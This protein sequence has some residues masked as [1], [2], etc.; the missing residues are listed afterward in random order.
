MPTPLGVPEPLART[1]GSYDFL[2]RRP[3]GGPVA[4][5]PC[6]PVRWVVRPD[7]APA[8]GQQTVRWAFDRLSRATGLQFVFEGTTDEAPSRDRTAYQPDRYG[9]RWA[10]LLVAWSWPPELRDLE[11]PAAGMAGPLSVPSTAA[12]G[13]V[14]VSGQ[15]VLDAPQLNALAADPAAEAV[16][17]AVV[18]HELAHVVGL[19][20]VDDPTQLM[21]P[22]TSPFV[23]DLQAGDLTGLD[24]LGR[25]P[26]APDL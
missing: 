18:L 4:F 12:G 10:P 25:G 14:A 15:A 5:D 16:L 6:R 7:G 26:C 23:T 1:S 19:D 21:N 2:Q 9:Y 24:Q 22:S 3:D 8:Y 20:H 11:G 13:R 17:R